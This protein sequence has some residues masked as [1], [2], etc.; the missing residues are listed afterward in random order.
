[1]NIF[2]W[3]LMIVGG[4]AGLLSTLYLLAAM[5]VIFGWKVYRSIKYRMSLFD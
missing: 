1:M 3:I 5:P 4:T 2:I